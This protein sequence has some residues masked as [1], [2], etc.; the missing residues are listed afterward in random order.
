M[1]RF[2][3]LAIFAAI[4][5]VGPAGYCQNLTIIPT[6]DASITGDP[7]GAQI[8]AT[9][10]QAI[11]F[12]NT[13]LTT[14]TAVSVKITFQ[15]MSGGL[16]MSSTAVVTDLNFSTYRAALASR[17]TT[18]NDTLALNSVQ[19][20]PN[21]PVNGTSLMAVTTANCRA[22]GISVNPPSDSTIS[23][24][25]SIMNL[26]HGVITD[27]NKFDLYAVASHE[28]NEALGLG[29]ALN[30]PTP[31]SAA[32]PM[33]LWRYDQNGARSY[34]ADPSAQSYFSLDGTTRIVQFNQTQTL[35]SG[36]YGD[37]FSPAGHTP[38][39]VQDAFATPGVSLDNGVAELTALDVI[40]Y[41]PV[42]E[43]AA[44]LPVVAVGLAAGRYRRHR[45]GSTHSAGSSRP[46]TG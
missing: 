44:V 20:G 11:S 8:Q 7:N 29:S 37:W 43:P 15:T 14:Q 18:A 33:D 25:T 21:N 31:S 22:L 17:A 24:N 12:Y 26:Q 19:A 4:F 9:I 3:S 46:V 13:N 16:G 36:D 30:S 41:T 38:V 28:I 10:N 34:T 40:G 39:R 35:G 2:R 23:L 42:P 45:T 27:A 5:S 1:T 6:F 32:R